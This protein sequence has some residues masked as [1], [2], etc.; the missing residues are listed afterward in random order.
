MGTAVVSGATAVLSNHFL[1]MTIAGLHVVVVD[2]AVVLG[3]HFKGT[4]NVFGG[5]GLPHFVRLSK[6][7]GNSP[8]TYFAFSTQNA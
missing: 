1:G 5:A 3:P 8:A 4:G 2:D 6:V 7:G